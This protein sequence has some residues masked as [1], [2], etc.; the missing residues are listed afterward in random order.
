MIQPTPFERYWWD[1]S[2]NTKKDHTRW[3]KC[4]ILVAQRWWVAH[5]SLAASVALLGHR[6]WLFLVSLDSSRLDFF[7]ST[8]GAVIE[9]FMCL[10]CF[11]YCFSFLFSLISHHKL[12]WEEKKT[13]K[14]KKERKKKDPRDTSKLRLWYFWYN[15]KD[16]DVTNLMTPRKVIDGDPSGSH[17]PPKE[18]EPPVT[19]GQQVWHIQVIIGDILWCRWTCLIDIFFMVLVMS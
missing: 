10:R 18:S 11:F 14:K 12:Q 7:K 9:V 19:F 8:S 6:W 16:F 3:P 13:K 4:A 2:N 15:W 17:L 1:G 5:L